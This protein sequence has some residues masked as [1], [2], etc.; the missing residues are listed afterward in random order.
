MSFSLEKVWVM[1]VRISNTYN[2]IFMHLFNENWIPEINSCLGDHNHI[3]IIGRGPSYSSVQQA[4]LM[5]REAVRR[6]AGGNLGGEFRNGP[7]EMVKEGFRAV[8]FA[9]VDN[10]TY[11]RSGFRKRHY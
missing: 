11:W 7:M 2:N 10:N 3:E 4:A 9:P 1:R 8:V 6:P 5:F